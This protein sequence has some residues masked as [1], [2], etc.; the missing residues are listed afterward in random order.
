MLKFPGWSGCTNSMQ[1]GFT[2]SCNT[3]ALFTAV[4][5][6][7]F[8]HRVSRLVT[9]RTCSM[10]NRLSSACKSARDTCISVS[11]NPYRCSSGLYKRQGTLCVS[12]LLECDVHCRIIRTF[13]NILLNYTASHTRNRIIH[14][15]RPENLKS[16][17]V[18]ISQTP[19]LTTTC[20]YPW[21][22][23]S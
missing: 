13:G 16:H 23:I 12:R 8:L 11:Y 7:T 5:P 19:L 3:L 17:T 9:A 6:L 10:P 14:G 15:H 22:T 21:A 2:L 20:S 1:S 18:F 4:L